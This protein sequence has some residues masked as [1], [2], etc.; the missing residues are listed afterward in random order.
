MAEARPS[1]KRF[2]DGKKR[3]GWLGEDKLYVDYHDREWGVPLKDER[4]LFE[5]L[6]LEGQ[7]AG[8]SWFIVLRK[9]ENYRKAFAK[10][11]PKKIARFG[12]K[13]VERLVKDEGIIRH[14]GKIEAIIANAKAVLALHQQGT[15]LSELVWGM[16]GGK[17]QH[18][19]IKSLK[20]I[21]TQTEASTA[22][23]KALLAAGF[24]FVGPTTCYAFMQAA[25]LVDDHVKG[26]LKGSWRSK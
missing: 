5:L 16:V 17:Q 23:S 3:C 1:L 4:A 9:R 6:C 25:G 2:A 26:C 10:F 18:N 8:L 13:D 15:S 22:L 19:K 7:Q 12:A 11:D 24:K 21:P 14:R 20:D